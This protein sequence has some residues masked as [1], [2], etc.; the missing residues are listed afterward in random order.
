LPQDHLL[1]V[2][3]TTAL[4]ISP[5]GSR[6]VYAAASP[7]GSVPRLYLREL[8]RFEPVPLS[9]TEGA[10]GPFFSPDG[11]W[12]GYFADGKLNKIAVEGGAPLE[13]CRVVQVV[14][15]ASWGRDGTILFSDS[16]D[17][18]LL[19]VP[20]AGGTPETFTTPAYA[21]GEHSH[22]W[23]QHLPDGEHVLFT[24]RRNDGTSIA[25]LSL[26]SGEWTVL[27]EG[28]GGARYL[29]A[30][31]LVYARMEGLVAARLDPGRPDTMGEP[32]LV[33]EDVYTIPFM[34]GTGLAAFDLSPTGVL[35]YVGGGAE[36]GENR[37][38]WVDRNGRT[39]PAFDEPGGYEWPNISPD[40]E[41]VAVNNR[42]RDGKI[43]IWLLDLERG[44][45]S[46]LTHAGN[47]IIPVWTP[48]SERIAFGSTRGASR[49][50]N[51][52]WK[53]ADGSRD[54]TLLDQSDH[55]RFAGSWSPDG[56]L[57]AFVEW[58]P[59]TMRDIWLLDAQDPGEST[60]I[61][62]TEYDEFS[63][64][65]S[66][67]GRWLAYNSNESGRYEIYVESFPRGRG[68]WL[69]SAGG[70]T[71]PVWSA[72]GSEL[73]Y[74]KGEAMF[75]VPV[76]FTPTFSAGAPQRLFERSLKRGIYDSLSYDV[77]PDGREFLMIER[78]LEL[79]PNQLHVVLDWD[80]ELR[81]RLPA[82]PD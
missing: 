66:P 20:A 54:A 30:G 26:R 3:D 81:R 27:A 33:V 51:L 28:V 64:L 69:V 7:P 74:R 56:K 15:G 9:G 43:G 57:L 35:V 32:V 67:D 79:V 23:P 60:P 49:V 10:L 37:L 31:Y 39:R 58:H 40:G 80:E 34:K 70:G 71:E 75:V 42:T 22:G 21:D 16:P 73:F 48:D 82:S 45:R 61:L 14:P 17:G 55:P 19:R 1:G 6:V 78:Q 41:R 46:R 76:R 50:C 38:V 12:L 53:P 24:T 52:Y 65:F 68:R 59:R 63:P 62:Q 36:A 72:D 5:D 2:A 4:A 11:E 13:I 25:L 18:G 29:P 47:D 77:S 44:S 8:D